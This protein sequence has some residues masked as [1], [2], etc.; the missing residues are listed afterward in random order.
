MDRAAVCVYAGE[1]RVGCGPRDNSLR[2]AISYMIEPDVLMRE[3][4]A[5]IAALREVMTRT[6]LG[7]LTRARGTEHK[8]PPDVA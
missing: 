1:D 5:A 2:R 4:E 6:T 3:T 8:R 7:P